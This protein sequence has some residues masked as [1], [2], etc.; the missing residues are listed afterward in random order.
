MS[1]QVTIQMDNTRPLY[2]KLVRDGKAGNMDIIYEM[3]R[4]IRNDVDYDKSVEGVA[5]HILINNGLNSYSPIVDQL[6]AIF[7]FVNSNVVYIQ[8]VA[9]RIESLK[10]ARQTLSDGFGDCDDE[11]VLNAT[12]LGCIGVEDVRIAMARYSADAETFGHVYTVAYDHG[13]R[14]VFDTNLPD[15]KLNKEVKAYEVKEIP[16]FADVKG[17]DG[18]SG[19]YYNARSQA[20]K[21]ARMAAQI[22]PRLGA[23]LPLGF[24]ADHALTTGVNMIESATGKQALSLPATAS[25]INEQLDQII[26]GL[27]GS[28]IAYDLAKSYGLQLAAQ[29]MAVDITTKDKYALDVVKQSIKNKLEFINN[30]PAYAE[31]NGIKVVYL[32]SGMM[33]TAG[34]VL[35]AGASYMAYKHYKGKSF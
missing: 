5:K 6:E 9:G 19:F 2:R 12:L 11:A 1:T 33:L 13:Q 8:D 23:V 28:R 20:R 29:L 16:V 30:F 27:T 26:V 31:T 24:L 7:N 25:S 3:I 17:L 10:S 34:A 18:L 22:V 32:H 35:A 14:Y 4:L 21:T 15:A